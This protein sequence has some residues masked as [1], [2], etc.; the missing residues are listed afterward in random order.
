MKAVRCRSWIIYLWVL[1][2]LGCA[3]PG[4]DRPAVTL[5]TVE[6]ESQLLSGREHGQAALP[7]ISSES[8][9]SDYLV[10]AA[11]N[12]PGLE[13]AFNRWKAALER[14]PQVKAMPDPRFTYAYFIQAV[15]TRVGPQRQRFGISQVFP[16]FGKL[17]L[18]GDRAFQAANA[19]QERYQAAKWNLFYRVKNSFYEYYYLS[20]AIA[21]TGNNLQL[22]RH[23]E[24]VARARYSSGSLSYADVTKAQV[25][26]GK[27]ED[28]L[29]TLQD[30]RRPLSAKLSAALNR[31]ETEVLPWPGKV[32]EMPANFSDEQL[33]ARLRGANPSLRALDFAAA[34]ERVGIE[35]AKKDFFPDFTLGIET[36][37]TEPALARNV[38]D[39]GKD[40]VIAS[41][42][43]NL[44][45]WLEKYRAGEREARA[46]YTAARKERKERE[47]TLVA[48]L[49]MAL[50]NFRDA[51]RKID[52]YGNALIP[53]AQ[54]AILVTTQAFEAGTVSFL[55]LLDSERSLLEF[56][57][58]Y[59][60]S[61]ANRAQRLAELEMLVAWEIPQ[62]TSGPPGEG[63][64]E[65]KTES[66]KEINP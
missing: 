34:S 15:E 20:R 27:V 38:P 32:A 47:N 29:R 43:I 25:E 22:L 5:S 58:T 3:G 4:K 57:L 8:T 49:K 17:S 50:Y 56:Q 13:S 19:E 2:A 23:F 6:T 11:L 36:I 51:E 35:L 55:N 16:W 24:N 33:L 14:I 45:I 12:N 52:L 66:H 18:R 40:P 59:E 37:Y 26:L 39:S 48:D 54:Q 30:L 44:P 42:S 62:S 63:G 1:L 64:T 41:V 9:L 60:R 65:G 31:S 46:R 53:K 10:Y 61:L 7:A 28:S 21:I